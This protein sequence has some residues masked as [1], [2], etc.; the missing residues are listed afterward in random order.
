[1]RG[2]KNQRL[3]N[4]T[5]KQ[6][7]NKSE[8]C[9]IFFYRTLT[10]A[11]LFSLGAC[12]TVQTPPS[13]PVHELTQRR[14]A[15]PFLEKPKRLGDE[16][17]VE[18]LVS[19]A[20]KLG[21]IDI[22]GIGEMLSNAP[23]DIIEDEDVTPVTPTIPMTANRIVEQAINDL[24][25]NRPALIRM[26]LERGATYFPM[27]EKI[28]EE[29]AV[30][31]ELKY[32]ALG[33]S[34]L[35]PT[36]RSHAGAAGMWQFMPATGRGAGL[37]IDNWV[38]ERLDPEKSTRAAARHLKELYLAYGRNWH[39]ALAGYNCSYRCI[40][41][42]VERAGGS[43]EDPPS[44]WAIYQYLPQETRAFV[45][46]FIA[47]ALIVSHPELYGISHHTVGEEL[48]Y[49]VVGIEGM[50][51][52]EEAARLAGTDVS[53]LKNLN[54]SLLQSRLPQQDEPFALKIPLN[55][56][57]QFV[58]AF[59][60]M[61]VQEK[62]A[63]A[64]YT[65]AS[66]DSLSAIAKRFSTSV[67]ELQAF[68]GINGHLIYAGQKLLLPGTGSLTG[69]VSIASL[70]HISIQ[71]GAP[72]FRPIELREEFQ[73]V[74]QSVSADGT[75]VM[76]VSLTREDKNKLL[77]PTV[78][79]VR[80]G[81]TLGEI[82]RNFEVPVHEIQQWNNLSTTLIRVGQELKIHTPAAEPTMATYEVKR[83]DNLDAIARR[84]GVTVDALKSWNDL[85][86]N[87]IYPGQNLVLNEE[88]L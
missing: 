67:P 54:P 62:T 41:R 60:Q 8:D 20:G 87:I 74:Q 48:A 36:A 5:L 56:Y 55:S 51:S 73:L 22:G 71:Y 24:L 15:P 17:V 4:N 10:L 29:E 12:S 86:S 42:A 66:G 3:F 64:E 34:G 85:S 30:P 81:D 63:P 6:K 46:K 58:S 45:P 38:D 35:Q 80:S 11:A 47:A 37:H 1:M 39:L 33:E 78:Y 82:A 25:Q 53:T 32:I 27:I 14:T 52:L 23:E 68:N 18:N 69:R 88:L 13:M 77:V 76:A 9:V 43:I 16:L 40:S 7:E 31:D 65:V 50:L 44:F 59:E 21:N 57:E 79:K 70:E 61:P 19:E 83:G 2:A 75:P 28:F 26:W 84:F 49:D 72:R